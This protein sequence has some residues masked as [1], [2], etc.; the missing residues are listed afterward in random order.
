MRL[1]MNNR[2]ANI[3]FFVL[4]FM[5]MNA[6]AEDSKLIHRETIENQHRLMVESSRLLRD[7]DNNSG[8]GSLTDTNVIVNS[9]ITGD[10]DKNKKDNG[11]MKGFI[12]SLSM[13]FFVEFGDRVHLHLLKF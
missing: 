1:H 8:R 12:N 10:V 3:L 2:L 13:I 7:G 6:Q 11:F 5:C 9:N 4:F